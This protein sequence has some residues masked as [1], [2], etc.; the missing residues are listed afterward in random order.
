M[1]SNEVSVEQLEGLTNQESA[2]V[3]AEHFAAVSNEYLPLNRND[4]PCYLPSEKP[5]QVDEVSV[6]EKINKLK[7]TRSTFAIDIPN[8]L[9]KEFAVELC[10]PL[11]NIINSCLLEQYYPKL[12][13][14]EFI[15][16]A[17]KISHPKVIKDL[18]KISST[19]DYSKVF[20]GFIKDWILE[21]I[22]DK[23]DVGQFG[24]QPGT[25]TE[26]MMVCLVDRILKLL[27]STTDSVAVIA[28]MIDWSSAFD[29]QDPTLAI[30]KFIKLGV[31]ASLIPLL[32]SYLEDRKM[33]V[34]F[35]GKMSNEHDLIGGGPQGTLLGLIEYL[36]QSND[37]ADCVSEE[38]RY[39]YID[40]LS[41]LELVF[42]SG[43]LTDFDCHRSVPSDIGVDQEYLP[44]DRYNTQGSLDQIASWTEENMMQIN[45]DKTN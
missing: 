11:S 19:S 33:R 44:P 6:Y 23:I 35:N 21:D 43:V 10:G 1:N 16:P 34:K 2:E 36:V 27:D 13:K 24:G 22:S 4:L 12:W 32:A 42:L 38:D 17:P 15:T 14:Y 20:E 18:R 37:A 39:K 25:G 30:Q 41:V 7:N 28:A 9:R 5:P 26:H 29:R 3:I 45:V 31:R 40:D 8:K